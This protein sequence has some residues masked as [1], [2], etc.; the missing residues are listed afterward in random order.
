MVNSFQ[1]SSA[2][3]TMLSVKL[4]P[5]MQKYSSTTLNL[6]ISTL[7]T[8]YFHNAQIMSYSNLIQEDQS[9]QDPIICLTQLVHHAN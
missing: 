9:S 1:I 4:R 2:K 3:D 8:L 5:L 6:T 7:R